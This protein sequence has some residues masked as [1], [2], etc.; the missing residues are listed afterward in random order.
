MRN[1]GEAF[2]AKGR[3]E[4]AQE[5][6]RAEC[7]FDQEEIKAATAAGEQDGR[8]G[9]ARNYTEG[10][11]GPRHSQEHSKECPEARVNGWG[12]EKKSRPESQSKMVNQ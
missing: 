2:Q 4:Q 9:A 5:V 12:K 3:A 10:E 6:R 11:N 7:G 1:L 8:G